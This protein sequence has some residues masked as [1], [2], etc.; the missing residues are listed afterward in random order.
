MMDG[1]MRDALLET[2][3]FNSIIRKTKNMKRV[4]LLL[5]CFIALGASA[6]G[7]L[8]GAIK[9]ARN[10]NHYKYP[11]VGGTA[12]QLEQTRQ[13]GNLKQFHKV[14][15]YS[16]VLPPKVSSGSIPSSSVMTARGRGVNNE[17]KENDALRPAEKSESTNETLPATTAKDKQV[18]AEM[19]FNTI[20]KIILAFVGLLSFC[21]ICILIA[22]F[23]EKRKTKTSTNNIWD[24]GDMS[25]QQNKGGCIYLPH[26]SGIL[27][28]T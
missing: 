7:F 26:R 15:P 20:V 3:A 2:P 22:S 24:D 14:P 11:I 23:L 1:A 13:V 5:M 6:H 25:N 9:S 8:K 19:V 4:L 10:M 18:E 21:V 12:H 27:M 17:M 16:P 28:R